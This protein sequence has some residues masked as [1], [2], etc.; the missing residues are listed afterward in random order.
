MSPRG[1]K[2]VRAIVREGP[3]ILVAIALADALLFVIQLRLVEQ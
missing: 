1:L 2:I 3:L